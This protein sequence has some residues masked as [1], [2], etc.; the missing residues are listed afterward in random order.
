MS[1]EKLFP[2]AGHHNHDSGAVSNGVKEADLTKELRNLVLCELDEFGFVDYE[3]DN[4]NDSLGVVIKKI[5]PTATDV[6]FDIHFNASS[7]PEATGTEVLISS[8]A[9]EKSKALATE[10]AAYTANLLGIKNRGVKTEAESARGRLAILNLKGAACL[11][12]VCFITN[13]NDLK[14]YHANKERLAK[15]LAVLLIKYHNS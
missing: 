14:S 8:Q 4:D 1:T 2:L 6:V 5:H 9:G 13:P 10:V 11:L 3:T 15:A 7:N 12:E